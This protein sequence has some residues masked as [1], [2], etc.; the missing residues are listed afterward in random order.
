MI[1]LISIIVCSFAAIIIIIRPK[2]YCSSERTKCII[3]TSLTNSSDKVRFYIQK[4]KFAK[5]LPD[6]KSATQP[7]WFIMEAY[8]KTRKETVL[9]ISPFNGVQM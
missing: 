3:L 2:K 5:I 6:L 8:F 7:I 1:R 9:I 4:N